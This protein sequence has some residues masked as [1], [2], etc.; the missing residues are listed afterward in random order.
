[1]IVPHEDVPEKFLGISKDQDRNN[2][3][4]EALHVKSES[5]LCFLFAVDPYQRNVRDAMR[6]DIEQRK[7]EIALKRDEF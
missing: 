2:E 3:D 6:N 4:S 7:D 1:M 5:G